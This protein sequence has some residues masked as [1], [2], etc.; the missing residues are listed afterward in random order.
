[1]TRR[2]TARDTHADPRGLD[3]VIAA[4]LRE[5]GYGR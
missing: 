2:L 5:P 3:A 1:M 4:N